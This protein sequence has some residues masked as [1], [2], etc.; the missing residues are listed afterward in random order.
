MAEPTKAESWRNL[1]RGKTLQ[2]LLHAGDFTNRFGDLEKV[3][4]LNHTYLCSAEFIFK[5]CY[6]FLFFFP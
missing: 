6:V 5:T 4:S 2:D 3:T 1:L